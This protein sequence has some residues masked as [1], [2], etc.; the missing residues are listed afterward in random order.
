M[1]ARNSRIICEGFLIFLNFTPF[2]CINK[3]NLQIMST[4]LNLRISQGRRKVL[5]TGPWGEGAV[6]M[7]WAQSAPPH[8]NCWEQEEFYY[9]CRENIFSFK[10]QKIKATKYY[11]LVRTCK[12]YCKAKSRSQASLKAYVLT[13]VVRTYVV[14]TC[15]KVHI[16]SHLMKYF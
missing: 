6:V 2:S 12:C 15:H 11:C 9:Y 7:W 1:W 10:N 5:N 3:K 14:H 13:Y 8:L 4:I 16:L